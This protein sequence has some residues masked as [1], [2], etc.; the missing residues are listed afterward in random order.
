MDVGGSCGVPLWQGPLGARRKERQPNFMTDGK[1]SNN[2][3]KPG[4]PNSRES[5]DTPA[6]VALTTDQMITAMGIDARMAD[7]VNPADVARQIADR[8]LSAETVDDVFAFAEAGTKSGEDIIGRPILITE[9]EWM[10]SGFTDGFGFYAL[11]TV[12]DGKGNTEQVSIGAGNACAQL[13]RLSRMD[14]KVTGKPA[15]FV[16][17]MTLFKRERATASGYYPLWFRPVSDPKDRM[18]FMSVIA[19]TV[20]ADAFA[21]SE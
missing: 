8:I 12:I 6:N 5:L 17:P 16:T 9:L 15:L 21:D 11:I 19:Q 1:K 20:P 18:G 2:S 13:F 14:D 3:D 7:A 10:R 4:I